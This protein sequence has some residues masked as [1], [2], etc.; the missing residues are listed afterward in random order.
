MP[1]FAR[2]E[3]DRKRRRDFAL[4]GPQIRHFKKAQDEAASMVRK[5]FDLPPK[6]DPVDEATVPVTLQQVA[7]EPPEVLGESVQDEPKSYLF[8]WPEIIGAL[9]LKD[10]AEMR[11]RI[12]RLNDSS[13]HPGPIAITGQ[14]GKPRVEKPKLITWWNSLEDSFVKIADRERDK[15]ASVQDQHNHGR[16]AVVVTNIEGSVQ[17]RRRSKQ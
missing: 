2:E 10:D 7:V 13:K 9:K 4:A 11:S 12:R 8:G 16:D 3:E 17:K 14:G 5:H 15:A 1:N 6:G